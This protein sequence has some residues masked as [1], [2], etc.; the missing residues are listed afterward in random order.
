MT[1]KYVRVQ[2]DSVTVGLSVKQDGRRYEIFL[3]VG[4]GEE[5]IHARI[6]GQHANAF[7]VALAEAFKLLEGKVEP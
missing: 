7:R 1:P 4:L 6:N 5:R 2:I 3:D